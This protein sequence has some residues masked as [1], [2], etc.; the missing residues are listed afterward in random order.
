MRRF[1]AHNGYESRDMRSYFIFIILLTSFCQPD[2]EELISAEKALLIEATN[3]TEQGYGRVIER[4][5]IPCQKDKNCSYLVTEGL[6]E[7]GNSPAITILE[8]DPQGKFYRHEVLN[9]QEYL[10]SDQLQISDK[11]KHIMF[12]T[13]S[14]DLS[15]QLFIHLREPLGLQ[16]TIKVSQE[17][18]HELR[19]ERQ[20]DDVTEEHIVI[21]DEKRIFYDGFTYAQGFLDQVRPVFFDVLYKGESSWIRM[22]NRG[23][24]SG[25]VFITFSFPEL[26]GNQDYENFI[27]FSANIPTVNLLPPGSKVKLTDGAE[28]FSKTVSIEVTKMPWRGNSWMRLPVKLT[29]KAGKM[30]VRAVFYEKNNVR[31]WPTGPI[32]NLTEV[33]QQGYHSYVFNPNKKDTTEELKEDDN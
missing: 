7:P 1:T 10:K 27:G 2:Q 13:V 8:F 26:Q 28:G 30:L 19:I 16:H 20:S 24:Y 9:N 11:K 31:R 14:K 3:V 17:L 5:N 29:K 12:I 33:D 25:K 21:S 22:V 15:K 18:K 6:A 32:R 4:K 23:A